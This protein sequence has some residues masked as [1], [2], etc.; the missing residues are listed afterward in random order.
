M[1]LPRAHLFLCSVATQTAPVAC[2]HAALL[3]G[4]GS[5]FICDV[6]KN[7]SKLI[8]FQ[9]IQVHIKIKP[10]TQIFEKQRKPSIL[11]AMASRSR[12]TSMKQ[13]HCQNWQCCCVG[14]GAVAGWELITGSAGAEL[15]MSSLEFS[16][17]GWLEHR[18]GQSNPALIIVLWTTEKLPQQ[19]L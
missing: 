15:Q 6:K 16:I 9:V 5:P 17:K 13:Y 4:G 1:Q 3:W 19:V 12:Y 2:C 14:Q 8:A 18:A 10:Q 7:F 11:T